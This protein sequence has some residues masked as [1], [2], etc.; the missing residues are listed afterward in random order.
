MTNNPNRRQSLL[1]G[2]GII[3]RVLDIVCGPGFK[4]EG[5]RPDGTRTCSSLAGS[6]SS[7]RDLDVTT[8]GS[9]LSIRADS[10]QLDDLL[11]IPEPIPHVRPTASSVVVG[12]RRR[13]RRGEPALAWSRPVSIDMASPISIGDALMVSQ[14][15]WK[16]GCAFTAG[17][18]GAPHEFVEVENE[19]RSL[20][21]SLDLLAETIEDDDGVL[22]RANDPTKAGVSKVLICARQ[23]LQDLESF[24]VRYQEIRRP[25]PITTPD[26]QLERSWKK[27][28]IKNWKTVWWTTEGGSIQALR[29]MLQ[30]HTSSITLTMQALQRSV[31]PPLEE[32]IVFLIVPPSKSLAR[33]ERTV[34]PMAVQVD[35]VHDLIVGRMNN[36]IDH[37]HRLMM[38]M[39]R[40]PSHSRD[41]S[42][43]SLMATSP[44][45][46]LTDPGLIPVE[47]EEEH[48][49]DDSMVIDASSP[50]IVTTPPSSHPPPPVASPLSSQPPTPDW[51]D[52]DWHIASVVLPFWRKIR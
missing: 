5:R 23:T 2:R 12:R 13:R 39:A 37:M 9:Y 25:D 21:T 43:P 48:D 7:T 18:A 11:P 51:T 6:S 36:K 52:L 40:Q 22:A 26:C 31:I 14:L 46:I 17:R 35:E 44:P 47:E 45:P 30:M 29:D 32:P 1:I 34:A 15:A 41:S 10:P 20:T 4:T 49:D 16:I 33:L 42:P 38:S 27:L 3:G 28:L 19:L 8:L 24:V 50:V